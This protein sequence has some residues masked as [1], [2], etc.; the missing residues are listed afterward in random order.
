M[1]KNLQKEGAM[2]VQSLMKISKLY[3]ERGLADKLNVTAS[4][5]DV[6]GQ[7]HRIKLKGVDRKAAKHAVLAELYKEWLESGNDDVYMI[8]MVTDRDDCLEVALLSP[9][10][11]RS[12]QDVAEFFLAYARDANGVHWD[13]SG[14]IINHALKRMIS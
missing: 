12:T 9:G 4:L 2:I 7:H 3:V 1:E 13:E 10:E 6:T 5:L 8:V 14:N 11:D